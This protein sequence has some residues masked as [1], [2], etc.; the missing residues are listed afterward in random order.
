MTLVIN[1]TIITKLFVLQRVFTVSGSRR[2]YFTQ[3]NTHISLVIVLTQMVSPVKACYSIQQKYK[4]GTAMRLLSQG[5]NR[6]AQWTNCLLVRSKLLPTDPVS[7]F[8]LDPN[9]P[10]FYVARLNSRADLAA[11]N[12]MCKKLGL[13]SPMQDQVLGSKT[14]PRFIG[15]KNPTPLLSKTPG[16]SPA[17]DQAKPFSRPCVRTPISKHK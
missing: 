13:P 16:P 17:I 4:P 5:L 10:T 11:L 8:D 14:L 12:A 15:I 2:L 6:V 3:E 1:A 9:L 7:Q